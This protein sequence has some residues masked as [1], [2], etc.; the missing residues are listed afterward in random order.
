MNK[1]ILVMVLLFSVT[2]TAE[3][4]KYKRSDTDNMHQHFRC[5]YMAIAIGLSADREERHL[6]NGFHYNKK[7]WESLSKEDREKKEASFTNQFAA[8]YNFLNMIAEY[9]R[10]WVDGFF[11]TSDAAKK[12]KIYYMVCEDDQLLFMTPDK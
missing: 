1:L 7:V 5:N 11:A 3:N 4:L 2:A 12:N 9:Q 10:G 8:E 6:A